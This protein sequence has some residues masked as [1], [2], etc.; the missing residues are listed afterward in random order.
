[1]LAISRYLAFTLALAAFTTAPS[2][3]A[4]P[5]SLDPTY[6]VGGLAISGSTT[7]MNSGT[8]FGGFAFLPDGSTFV[9]SN[10][11]GASGADLDQFSITQF[12]P[13]GT[14][15][16]AQGPSGTWQNNLG[17]TDSRLHG[18]IAT[19]NRSLVGTGYSSTFQAIFFSSSTTNGFLSKPNGC[20]GEA[21]TTQA[22]NQPVVVGSCGSQ[23][24][25]TRYDAVPAL[26]FNVDPTF[27]G[28]AVAPGAIDGYFNGA[29]VDAAGRV[30]AVGVREYASGPDDYLIVRILANGQLDPTFHDEENI[31]GV[32]S[33]PIG[34]HSDKANAVAVQSDGKLVV[35]GQGGSNTSSAQLAQVAR[36]NTNGSIDTSFGV[37]GKIVFGFGNTDAPLLGVAVQP[38]G[39][40]VLVGSRYEP[41]TSNNASLIIRLLSNGSFDET[42]APG[43]FTLGVPNISESQST[44]IG[45]LADGKILVGQIFKIAGQNRPAVLRLAGGELP[46]PVALS[47]KIK[48]PS[49]SKYKAKKFKKFSG[50]AAG[51]GL[52]KVQISVLKKD[53]KLL[54]K[55][56]RC[57]QLSS[58]RAKLSKFKAVKKKCVPKKWLN[59]TGTASWSYKLKK[60]LKRGKYTLFVRSVNT[61]GVAQATPTKKSFTLTK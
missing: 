9:G 39:K 37:G 57:L 22:N 58:S 40:L 43:G 12:T 55:K 46:V 20:R 41:G 56:R 53:S 18:L 10:Q 42:F 24:K 47:A 25:V 4:A 33:E 3:L 17:G 26:G 8:R 14:P 7:D 5:S 61:A 11:P 21:V 32:V 13:S 23:P 15:D 36:F 49:K 44:G 60:A 38:N 19:P 51:D 27:D 50:T 2:A 52:A 45:L 48:T 31:P 1:M 29:T 59:A 28:G 54:N 35:V 34:E 6:G 30:V 16:P